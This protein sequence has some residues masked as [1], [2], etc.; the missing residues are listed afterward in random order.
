MTQI[1]KSDFQ[2]DSGKYIDSVIHFNKTIQIDKGPSA[3]VLISL[4]EY[5]S[6]KAT[7]TIKDSPITSYTIKHAFEEAKAGNL[8]SVNLEEL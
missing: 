4:E 6:I 1:N 5:N 8:I 2:S 7:R 3:V